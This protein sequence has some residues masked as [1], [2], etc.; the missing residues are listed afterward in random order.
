[1]MHVGQRYV[2]PDPKSTSK[3]LFDSEVNFHFDLVFSSRSKFRFRFQFPVSFDSICGFDLNFD[4]SLLFAV[5]SDCGDHCSREQGK[6][7]YLYH[8]RDTE[9][10]KPSFLP[11]FVKKGYISH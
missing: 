5:A 3:S 6:I 1:M 2:K 8:S 4:F 9:D 7:L 11:E 10:D